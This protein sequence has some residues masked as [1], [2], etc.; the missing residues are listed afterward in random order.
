[1]MAE[2]TAVRSFLVFHAVF[3]KTDAKPEQDSNWAAF[4]DSLT[5]PLE[6]TKGWQGAGSVSLDFPGSDAIQNAEGC[7]TMAFRSQDR[8]RDANY[9]YI[10]A[11]GGRETHGM[12]GVVVFLQSE[13]KDAHEKLRAELFGARDVAFSQLPTGVEPLRNFLVLGAFSDG[14]WLPD[15]T[16]D[17]PFVTKE[18]FRLWGLP[19]EK[20]EGDVRLALAAGTNAE[21]E[22]AV[23]A[24]TVGPEDGKLPPH[25]DYQ[26]QVA[27]IDSLIQEFHRLYRIPG[28]EREGR[29]AVERLMEATLERLK[30]DSD[31]PDHTL[32]RDMERLQTS[33][34]ELN[35]GVQDLRRWRNTLRVAQGKRRDLQPRPKEAAGGDEATFSVC[36]EYA[37]RADNLE[38]ALQTEMDY[39]EPLIQS[40]AAIHP[41][42][43]LR[44]EQGRRKSEEERRIR[45]E[46]RNYL[47]IVQ[48]SVIGGLGVFLGAI[49][50]MG[51]ANQK[52]WYAWPVIAVLASIG[53]A[54]P[55]LSLRWHGP[56]FLRRPLER[57]AIALLVAVGAYFA[58]AAVLWAGGFASLLPGHY[59]ALFGLLGFVSAFAAF[60]LRD[61]NGGTPEVRPV[62][63]AA[64]AEPVSATIT[65]PV[66]TAQEEK[67]PLTA[68]RR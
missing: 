40:I 25:L 15:E 23:I 4:W 24:Y 48:T 63:S 26:I 29:K 13:E 17:K 34:S 33:Q 68:G 61:R 42:Y 32:L 22:A 1:M 66:T 51:E 35:L 31:A 39:S 21:T 38:R 65:Q 5:K 59:A 55:A 18:G 54:V 58:A 36:R 28:S 19:D 45:D 20:T 7:R 11:L 12:L 6:M 47:N 9:A 37:A 3:A 67:I 27:K 52:H 46:E 49:Q 60:Q 53:F 10:Y 41:I 57:G 8:Q 64:K 14:P 62:S 2:K 50:A 43:L 44:V 56:Q 30:S 16:K